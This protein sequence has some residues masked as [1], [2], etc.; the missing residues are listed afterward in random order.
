MITPHQLE[1][2]LES[3]SSE[4]M[5][6][7]FPG[8]KPNEKEFPT[9]E[10]KEDSGVRFSI[11]PMS[12]S[13]ADG[14][15]SSLFIEEDLEEQ[16]VANKPAEPKKEEAQKKNKKPRLFGKINEFVGDLYG[17]L[18]TS[19]A[20]DNEDTWIPER[21]DVLE[22]DVPQDL[23]ERTVAILK[24]IEA[25]QKRYNFTIEEL[26][27]VLQYR[28]ERKLSRLCITSRNDIILMDYGW[29]KVEMDTLPKAVFLLYLSHED[30]IRF[31]DLIDF[32]D[33]LEGIYMDLSGRSDMAAMRRSI[34]ALVNPLSNSLNEKV[35]RVKSAFLN[36]L[37]DRIAQYYYID[38]EKGSTK[39]IRLNRRMVVWM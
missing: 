13:P 9:I 33:E 6:Y 32:R 27:S 19:D 38:G 14:E 1:T 39:S 28:A 26:E 11:E 31:K 30:G 22:T 21:P 15:H 4:A 24:E 36:V 16:I 3:L 23:D 29:K 7:L 8:W 12:I 35:S 10:E 34:D 25:L 37:D 5:S 20:I 2:I 18:D 17:D